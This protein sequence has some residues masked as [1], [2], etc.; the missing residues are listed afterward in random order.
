MDETDLL[1]RFVWDGTRDYSA[2]L[3]LPV[4]LQYWKQQGEQSLRQ[5]LK[6]QLREGIR[7]LAEHWHPDHAQVEAWPGVVTL[8]R[9]DSSMLSPMALVSLPARFGESNTSTDAKRVQDYLFEN[10]IEVT[11]KC[12]NGKLFTRLSCHVYNNANDFHILGETIQ[13]YQQ[14]V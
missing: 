9:F 8:T 3:A 13:R 5:K 14:C 1:S 2:A 11:I 7:I 12:I 10:Q 6:N 4:V